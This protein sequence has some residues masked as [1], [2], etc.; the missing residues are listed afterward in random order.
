MI[1]ITSAMNGMN[2]ESTC[3]AKED[4]ALERTMATAQATREVITIAGAVG[5]P[6]ASMIDGAAGI[7]TNQ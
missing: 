6:T 7:P 4:Q 3:G 1:A 2:A 5:I